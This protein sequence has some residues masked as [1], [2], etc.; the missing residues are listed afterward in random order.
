LGVGLLKEEEEAVRI[1]EILE[2]DV[3]ECWRV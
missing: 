2:D 3:A 1:L